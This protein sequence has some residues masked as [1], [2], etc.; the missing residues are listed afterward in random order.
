MAFGCQ[1]IPPLRPVRMHMRWLLAPQLIDF[2]NSA[3][4]HKLR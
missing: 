4:D 1:L 2:G 3:L